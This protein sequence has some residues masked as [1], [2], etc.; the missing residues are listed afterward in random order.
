M[1]QVSR[2]TPVRH[3]SGA[4]WTRR[5]DRLAVEEPLEIRIGGEPFS[6]TMRTPGED[7]NLVLGYLYFY[8]AGEAYALVSIGLISFSAV[9]QFAPAIIGG[10]YWKGGTRLGATCGLAAGFLVWVYTLLLPSFAKSA[11][12]P[13]KFLGEGMFGIDAL[14]PQQLFGLGGF[15]EITHCLFWSLLAIAPFGIALATVSC[16]AAASSLMRAASSSSVRWR[17]TP[18]SSS[19]SVFIEANLCE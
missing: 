2:R 4:D 15:D 18:F 17:T 19:S 1:A 11:W 14:R 6:V 5:S 9:A 16:P 12:L 10:I 7:F 13:I 8:L 3:L